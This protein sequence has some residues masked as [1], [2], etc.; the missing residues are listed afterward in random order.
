MT[1]S[2]ERIKA[3]IAGEETDR[4]GFWLGNPH[5]D[6]WPIYY[7]YFKST[8]GEAIRQGLSDDFRWICPEWNSYKHP[9]G[10]PIFNFQS[11]A[12]TLSAPGVFSDC[13][14]VGEVHDFAWPNPDYLNFS[15]TLKDLSNAGNVYR[16]SGFWSPFYHILADF[17]GMENYFLKM[18]INPDVV[19]AVTRH[20]VDFYLEANKRFFEQAGDLMDGYFFGNDFG[21][22]YDLQISPAHF[23][24]FVFPYF[25]ELTEQAHSYNYQVILHSCGA[26][27]R[28][29]PDIIKMGVD[30]L[31]PLQALASNMDAESLSRFKGKIAFIGGI[32]TQDLLVNASPEK[33]REEVE[34][35][36]RLLGPRLVISPSHEALLPNVPPENARAMAGAATGCC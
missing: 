2:R 8:D 17:F 30:A 27:S 14:D 1:T 22:Q 25:R 6:T 35:V 11:K 16:A 24:E 12:K 21:T 29:I 31:H 7:N 5:N 4:C 28:V 32:D 13:E 34:R 23:G 10:K 15:E 33:V 18:C 9:D 3:I 19:H 26:I 20:I 36:K